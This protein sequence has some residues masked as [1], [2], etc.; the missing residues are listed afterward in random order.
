MTTAKVSKIMATKALI[1][2][3]TEVLIEDSNRSEGIDN[4]NIEQQKG[5]YQLICYIQHKFF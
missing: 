5:I 1:E 2:D 4:A 3:T